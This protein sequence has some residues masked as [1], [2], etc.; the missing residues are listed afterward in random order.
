M[1]TSK[2]VLISKSLYKFNCVKDVVE[3]LTM[4]QY[5]DIHPKRE[6]VDPEIGGL[7]GW[8]SPWSTHAGLCYIH[9][10]YSPVIIPVD[11]HCF[12]I[13]YTPLV[14]EKICRSHKVKRTIWP[15]LCPGE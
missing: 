12:E 1:R 5:V 8:M 13:V 7:V 15:T 10:S 2:I 11:F 14:L 9:L 4:S 6:V 3:T